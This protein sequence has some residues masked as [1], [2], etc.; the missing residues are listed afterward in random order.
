MTDTRTPAELV[1]EI[2]AHACDRV[3]RPM[4]RARGCADPARVI[5]EGL[6]AAALARAGDIPAGSPAAVV[7]L[8]PANDLCR[9]PRGE[10]GEDLLD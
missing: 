5:A 4:L 9:Q 6:F 10:F 1:A 2:L 8:S 7:R 3:A